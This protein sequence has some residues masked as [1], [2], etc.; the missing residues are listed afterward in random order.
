[1]KSPY[2]IIY[3]SLVTEKGTDLEKHNKYLFIVDRRANK[4]EIRNAIERIYN[5]KVKSV[6]VMNTKPKPKRM[7]YRL[8]HTPSEKK[9]VVTLKSGHKITVK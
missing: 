4:I 5:V 6:C 1:M 9:A 8:G 7:R 3:S 2:T